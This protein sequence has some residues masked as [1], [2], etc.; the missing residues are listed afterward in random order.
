MTL[1][2]P[3][4]CQ[5][6]LSYILFKSAADYLSPWH[7]VQFSEDGTC[8]VLEKWFRLPYSHFSAQLYR[9]ETYQLLPEFELK[10]SVFNLE[11]R[12]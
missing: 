6:N 11:S 3:S 9:T 10:L 7:I 8:S 1:L 4:K 5:E 12:S 2:Q